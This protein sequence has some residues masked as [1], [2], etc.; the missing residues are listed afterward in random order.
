MKNNMF[1][2]SIK[3]YIALSSHQL[4][5]DIIFMFSQS[6]RQ[7]ARILSHIINNCLHLSHECMY[8]YKLFFCIRIGEKQEEEEMRQ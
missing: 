2:I 8:F 7:A 4:I 6:Y 1:C 3:H 5:F